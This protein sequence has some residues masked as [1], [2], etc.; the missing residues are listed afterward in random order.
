MCN[1]NA[2]KYGFYGKVIGI[3]NDDDNF[4]FTFMPVKDTA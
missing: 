3:K 2:V 1:I 4:L